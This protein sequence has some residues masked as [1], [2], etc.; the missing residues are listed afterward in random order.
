[1]RSEL[2]WPPVIFRRIS[3]VVGIVHHD[4]DGSIV[5]QV[6]ESGA[7]A[8][9]ELGKSSLGTVKNAAKAAVDISEEQLGLR[10]GDL[11]LVCSDI[12]L[13]VTTDN[14]DVKEP[15]IVVVHELPAKYHVRVGIIAQPHL[16]TYIGEKAL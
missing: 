11:G 15:I 16:S 3:E 12:V 10:V 13:R 5:V 9:L 4:V 1:M 14:E 2:F 6:T 8:H 7:A